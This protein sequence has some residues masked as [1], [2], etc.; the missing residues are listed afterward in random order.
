MERSSERARRRVR[1]PLER[2][3]V[4]KLPSELGSEGRHPCDIEWPYRTL[5]TVG[6]LGRRGGKDR[7]PWAWVRM[8]SMVAGVTG[9]FGMERICV[10]P[11]A[12]GEEGMMDG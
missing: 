2:R 5:K 9:D 8:L 3:V 7:V 1:G 6:T 12:S 10:E 4:R 11:E